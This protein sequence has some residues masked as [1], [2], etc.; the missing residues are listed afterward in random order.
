MIEYNFYCDESCHLEHDNSNVMV[1]GGVWCPKEKRREI[2]ERI[3]NISFDFSESEN[4]EHNT[5]TSGH[6][7]DG[8]REDAVFDC[9]EEVE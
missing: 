9:Q 8:L 6:I 1:L 3:K 5:S 4:V 2:N 7:L